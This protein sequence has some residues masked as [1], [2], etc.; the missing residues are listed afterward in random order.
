MLRMDEVHVVRH[1]VLVEGLSARKV[2]EQLG[3]SRNTVRRYLDRP[4]PVRTEQAPRPTPTRDMVQGRLL[5]VAER[6]C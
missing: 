1:K 4:A 6:L 3:V 2:A 5:D